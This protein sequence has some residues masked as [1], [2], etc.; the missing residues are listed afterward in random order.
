MSKS[1]HAQFFKS[2]NN[3]IFF[4]QF[5]LKL[6]RSIPKS[7]MPFYVDAFDMSHIV[8]VQQSRQHHKLAAFNVAFNVDF[9][10]VV[11]QHNRRHNFLNVHASTFLRNYVKN[12]TISRI[13][14]WINVQ[15]IGTHCVIIN[16]FA[17]IAVG[18]CPHI[19]PL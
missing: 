3:S 12:H 8:R 10:S 11:I 2:G 9:G 15:T 18:P 6:L 16:V 5:G 1:L 14:L 7:F 13:I 19:V 17:H 4:T